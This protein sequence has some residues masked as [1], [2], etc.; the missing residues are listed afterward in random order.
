[1]L[2][3]GIRQAEFRAS[4]GDR[5]RCVRWIDPHAPLDR[6]CRWSLSVSLPGRDGELCQLQ[7]AGPRPLSGGDRVA[8]LTLLL[9]S[10][11]GQFAAHADLLFGPPVPDKAAADA[12]SSPQRKAA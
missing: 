5:L 3:W 6:L 11:G 1:L 2:K 9:K 8:A 4:R 10:Y 12:R 7:T